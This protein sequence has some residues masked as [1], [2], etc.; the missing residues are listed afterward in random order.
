[1]DEEYTPP[2]LR[3]VIERT[4]DLL[5]TYRRNAERAKAQGKRTDYRR[6]DG[7]ADAYAHMLRMFQEA[8]LVEVNFLRDGSVL[9]RF[10]E[11]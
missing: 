6:Q 11:D 5:N 8:G 7:E 10:K 4:A 2:T 3:E 1:M 9:L